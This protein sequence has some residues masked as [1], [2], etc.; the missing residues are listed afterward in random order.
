MARWWRVRGGRAVH[1]PGQSSAAASTLRLRVS[2]RGALEHDVIV[3][4]AVREDVRILRLTQIFGGVAARGV[5]YLRVAGA[6][7]VGA[8][9]V[10]LTPR[11]AA[12][13][14]RAECAASV[15]RPAPVGE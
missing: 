5:D 7:G 13:K 4:V 14:R 9:L 2:V 10:G 8:V 3:P 11:L 15:P 6:V 1:S 12:P